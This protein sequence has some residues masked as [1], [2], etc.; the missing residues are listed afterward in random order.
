MGRSAAAL[1]HAR[2]IMGKES[3]TRYCAR[4]QQC[5][6]YTAL[7]EPV[8]LNRYN[9]DTVCG[10]CRREEKN[11][12]EGRMVNSGSGRAYRSAPASEPTK[13]KDTNERVQSTGLKVLDSDA[14]ARIRKLKR[15]LVLQLFMRSGP[16]WEAVHGVR[17]RWGIVATAQLPPPT[18]GP[19]IPEGE[20]DEHT[21][22]E[23]W[24]EFHTRWQGGVFEIQ[25]LVIPER[26]HDI[27]FFRDWFY[28]LS[29]CVLYDPPGTN[30]LAFA[31]YGDPKPTTI[32]EDRFDDDDYAELP[33]MVDPP[34]KTLRDLSKMRD[35][36]WTYSIEEIL[37][38]L[39][40][41]PR[42]QGDIR[43]ML[44][45]VEICFEEFDEEQ[46]ET[47]YEASEPYYIEVDEHTT[48]EDVKRAFKLIGKAQKERQ[49]GTRPKRDRLTAVECA[50]LRESDPKHWTYKRLAHQYGWTGKDAVRDH[51]SLGLEILK[52]ISG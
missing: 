52:N 36:L 14:G 33:H 6:Q 38:W 41:A 32:H 45:A 29:A 51:V 30:L 23:E 4:G 50:T 37:K 40:R 17:T 31:A 46:R 19:P 1:A 5:T 13:E 42:E 26:Y 9:T 24:R 35:R 48:L 11:N 49:P 8:K 20:P 22:Q 34:I 39:L 44:S 18:P 28:F 47:A 2:I 25:Q 7:G 15:D 12:P 3:M 27:T 43:S 16:F 10:Q 21:E